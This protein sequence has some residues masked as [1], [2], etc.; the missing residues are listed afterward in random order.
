MMAGGKDAWGQNIKDV[1]EDESVIWEFAIKHF[2][3][4]ARHIVSFNRYMLSNFAVRKRNPIAVVFQLGLGMF[5]GVYYMPVYYRAL[6]ITLGGVIAVTVALVTILV[7]MSTYQILNNI[8][9]E[10]EYREASFPSYDNSGEKFN[11]LGVELSVLMEFVELCGGRQELQGLTTTEV[12]EKY[13]MPLTKT[14]ASSYC[15][16]LLRGGDGR[17]KK[18][19][20]FISHAW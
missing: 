16:Q 8:H 13:L 20:V 15:D 14:S 1:I 7:L 18:A 3:W 12:S 5:F 4:S 11:E 19:N 2:A 10:V 17:V 9:T 6:G